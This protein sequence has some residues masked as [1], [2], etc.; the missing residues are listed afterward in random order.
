M[1]TIK[2][3][4][5]FWNDRPCN[6]HHSNKTIGT[7][8]YFQEVTNRKYTIEPHIIEF[9][10]FKKYDKKFVL[11]VGCGIGTASQ[12]FIESG[13]IYSGIDLSDKSVEIANQ[14]LNVFNLSG[15]IFQANIEELNNVNNTFF[16]LIYSFGVLHHTPNIEKAIDNIYNMLKPGGPI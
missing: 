16:D 9:A 7:K 1:D 8:E 14:R 6:I 3:V 13:A 5:K 15:T 10:D 11:E 12:S 2:N 4:Y